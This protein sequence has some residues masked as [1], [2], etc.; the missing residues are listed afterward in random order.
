[1]RKAGKQELSFN[2]PVF[3]PSSSTLP[4]PAGGV[5]S[6]AQAARGIGRAPGEVQS[7]AQSTRLLP[8]FVRFVIFRNSELPLLGLLL[9][10]GTYE[11]AH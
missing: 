11:V 7:S 3:L 4:Q 5:A 8:L 10:V 2:F 6:S 9:R 1:M